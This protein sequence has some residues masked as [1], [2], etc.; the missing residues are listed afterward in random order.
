MAAA[1]SLGKGSKDPLHL[2]LPCG[3][4]PSCPL[5]YAQIMGGKGQQSTV[6]TARASQVTGWSCM[7]GAW[8]VEVQSPQAGP[9]EEAAELRSARGHVGLVPG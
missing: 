5:K 4:Q 6:K 1:S 9:L 3:Q 2:S 7:W 8:L